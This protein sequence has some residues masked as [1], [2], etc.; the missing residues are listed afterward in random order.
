MAA[1]GR[2]GRAKK[3]VLAHHLRRHR[4]DGA[5]VPLRQAAHQ[6]VC[7]QRASQRAWLLAPLVHSG[8]FDTAA[9][10]LRMNGARFSLFKEK[11]VAEQQR[12]APDPHNSPL[13]QALYL[14]QTTWLPDQQLE[15]IDR[16]V[17]GVEARLPY[18]DH[19]IA[20]YVS[21]L[22]DEHRVRGLTTKWILREAARRLLPAPL[23]R[24]AKG[25]WRIELGGWLRNELRDFVLDHLQGRSSVTPPY[26]DAAALD[27]VLG[28]PA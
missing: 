14:D 21:A 9:A 19:R 11:P 6:A 7:R 20:E 17:H 22:P 12:E 16:T 8:R 26:Y 5:A 18:L 3:N 24:R 28:E 4:G 10:P 27:K 13:R 25:G 15:R 1:A 23:A 2:T